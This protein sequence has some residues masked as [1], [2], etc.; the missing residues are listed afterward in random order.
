[1]E[2]KKWA[3]HSVSMEEVQSVGQLGGATLFPL[4]WLFLAAAADEVPLKC[5]KLRPQR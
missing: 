4:K 5:H 2:C 1:M 3:C